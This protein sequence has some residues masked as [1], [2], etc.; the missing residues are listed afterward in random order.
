MGQLRFLVPPNCVS[1]RAVETACV[2]GME[3]LPWAGEVALNG[4]ELVV[5]REVSDSGSFH[6]LWPVEGAAR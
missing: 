2:C 3:Q 6:I 5:Q 4:D 1:P